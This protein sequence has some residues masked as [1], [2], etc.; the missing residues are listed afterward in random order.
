MELHVIFGAGQVGGPLMQVLRAQGHRVRVVRRSRVEVP[1]GVELVVGDAF[2][3][4]FCVQS[5]ANA[6]SVYHCLNVPYSTKAWATALPTL[7]SNLIEAAGKAKAR[8]VVFENLYMLGAPAGPLTE[9]SP[10]AP[11]SKKGELRAAL[12]NALFEA[13]RAGQ[14]RA[15]AGRASHLFGPNVT[16][17]QIGEQLFTRV[18]AGKSAQVFGDVKALHSFSYA[19]DVARGLA[20]LGSADDALGRAWMLPVMPPQSSQAFY[21]ALFAALGVSPR[22]D[23][24][25][26]LMLSMLGLFVPLLRE[27]VEMN[28]EWQRDFVVSDAAFVQR[29]GFGATSPSEA[30]AATAAWAKRTFSPAARKAA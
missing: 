27:L 23:V 25:S 22:V 28:Y 7:Q 24:I 8:L 30:M 17:S 18:L 19:P 3:R 12:T 14:V 2:D 6:T 9:A 29:F 26:P 15:V 13:H 1:A 20:A 10:L 5:A 16:Q 4:S 11:R 21:H